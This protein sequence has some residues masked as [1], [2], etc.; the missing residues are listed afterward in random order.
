[1]ARGKTKAEDGGTSGAVGQVIGI[2]DRLKTFVGGD[3]Y[4]IALVGILIM[5]VGGARN[6]LAATGDG[7][8]KG[9]F[10]IDAGSGLVVVAVTAAAA[11]R[12]LPPLRGVFQGIFFRPFIA[13]TVGAVLAALWYAFGP[14]EVAQPDPEVRFLR[15]MVGAMLIGLTYGPMLSLVNARRRTKSAGETLTLFVL[16]AAAIAVAAGVIVAVIYYGGRIEDTPGLIILL[17]APGQADQGLVRYAQIVLAVCVFVLVM[18]ALEN[19]ADA[20]VGPGAAAART[21]TAFALLAGF[22]ALLAVNAGGDGFVPDSGEDISA[23][24]ARRVVWL[25]VLS[26]GTFVLLTGRNAAVRG[27]DAS[28][29][30]RMM[31]GWRLAAWFDA[32]VKQSRR[33]RARRR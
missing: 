9:A 23:T 30:T 26:F 11:Y 21:V 29:V 13:G 1:M 22:G 10:V 3:A 2:L 18:V 27:L 28:A 15:G 25:A 19:R 7:A 12:S 4:N 20:D 8:E 24:V 32:E 16:V 6:V 31:T 33:I 5:C 17:G 14:P